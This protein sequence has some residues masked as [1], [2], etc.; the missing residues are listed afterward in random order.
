MN[1]FTKSAKKSKKTSTTDDD[2]PSRS[3]SPPKK[4]PFKSNKGK[5]EN[6]WP[7]PASSRNSS[8]PTR[9]QS[10][11]PSYDPNSHPLNLPPEQLRRLSALSALSNSNMSE[12]LPMDMD[13]DVDRPN[14]A[15][16]S[17]TPTQPAVPT[18]PEVP[19]GNGVN[20]ATNG[21]AP[22]P[23]PHK[24]APTSPAPAPVPT[25]ED[26]EAFKTA[27]NKYYKAK[28]YKRAIEEY[29]KGM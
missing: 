11:S 2:P 16:S 21:R 3:P 1:F 28:E 17:P 5:D 10:F 23:P 4:S 26:A 7:G 25:A 9:A 29:T 22:T 12:P 8:S 14:G 24:S 19:S 13:M 27:G 18:S 20:G 6:F 15:P